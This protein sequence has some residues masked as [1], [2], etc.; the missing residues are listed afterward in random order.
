MPL[1]G[2]SEKLPLCKGWT[3]QMLSGKFKDLENKINYC[4]VLFSFIKSWDTGD[5]LFIQMEY[6]MNGDLYNLINDR[7]G[8][9]LIN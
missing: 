9:K 2:H 3:I 6:C 4:I 1:N 7:K 5:E 8:M